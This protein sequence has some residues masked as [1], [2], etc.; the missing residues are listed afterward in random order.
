LSEALPAAIVAQLEG[1][2]QALA[3]VA[4]A[5][6]DGTL[7]TLEAA[8]LTAIR[9]AMP[10]LLGA[11]LTE[12][13]SSLQPG[14][15]GRTQGCPSCGARCRVAGWRERTVT[16][17]C[18]AV[19]LERP[20]YHCKRCGRGWSPADRTWGL[21]PRERLSAGLAEWLIDLG[22]STSFADAAR[23]LGKLTG[24]AVSAE[25][26]R[27]QTEE[28]GLALETADAEAA[29]VVQASREAAGKGERAPGVLVVEIDGVMVRYRSGWHEVKLGLVGGQVEGELRA[30][31][32]VGA[33]EPP[34]AFG[35]RVVAEAAR[36][37]ALEI[38]GW[39]G[40]GES[41]ATLREVVVLADGAVWIWL[42][43]AEHFGARIEIV[44]FYHAAEHVWALANALFG[45]GTYMAN[46]WAHFALVA[47]RHAAAASLLKLL[48]QITPATPAAAEVLRRE[49]HY[50]RTHQARMDYPTYRAQ[51]LPLGS[52]AV[53]SAG[54]HLVQLRMK[55][56]GAR[57]SDEGGKG[58][59]AV[60][61]RLVS[62][63]P[64]AA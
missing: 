32:Y 34:E 64:L 1:L 55:R 62:A 42:L 8:T 22:A 31:S 50:F 40:P 35:P 3:E 53:E 61:C 45:E 18:G 23:Q 41:L 48:A 27:Q 24:W 10:D 9:K 16:T 5:H 47:L 54:K 36:R 51:G 43:A 38:V 56:A 7:A 63:R 30:L 13:T 49:T 6:R 33:R 11:V 59:L 2:G 15:V 12:S 39:E 19:T 60:R 28:R 57:W 21:A 17:V 29:R 37:G 4:R 58:V 44:D 14:G 52:G 26:I 20:W 46:R 25:T